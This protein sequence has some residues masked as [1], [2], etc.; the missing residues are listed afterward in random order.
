MAAGAVRGAGGGRLPAWRH[1][2]VRRDGL[3]LAAVALPAAGTRSPIC[4]R[5]SVRC[6]HSGSS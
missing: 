1:L 2:P 6:W 5:A 3:L 4:R